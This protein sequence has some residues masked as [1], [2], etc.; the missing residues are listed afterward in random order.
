MYLTT[1]RLNIIYEG[2]DQR[3]PKISF[4]IAFVFY[5]F[6]SRLSLSF[7][8]LFVKFAFA[9]YISFY[10]VCLRLL[11]FFLYRL[12]LPLHYFFF[13]FASP[14]CICRLHYFSV[15]RLPLPFTQLFPGCPFL[16]LLHYFSPW[17][18]C[19]KAK[20]K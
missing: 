3:K 2:V 15:A 10:P 7:T 8:L 9:F 19:E 11:L 18:S 1:F 4:P 16:C 17:K 5:I 14:I 6:P 20:G 13:P 12:P